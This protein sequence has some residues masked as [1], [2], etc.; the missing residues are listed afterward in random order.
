MSTV[1]KRLVRSRTDRMIGGV[2]A[3]LGQY[4]GIDPTVV[5]VIFALGLFFGLGSFFFVYLALWLIVP[6]EPATS[7]VVISPVSEDTPD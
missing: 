3:G 6:E 5:R 2:C 4:L 1:E 7:P